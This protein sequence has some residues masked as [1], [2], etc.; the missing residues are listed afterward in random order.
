MPHADAHHL[1]RGGGRTCRQDRGRGGRRTFMGPTR[2]SCAVAAAC[3]GPPWPTRSTS[4]PELIR[5][6]CALAHGCKR[7][8]HD[9][10][11]TATIQVARHLARQPCIPWSDPPL[12]FLWTLRAVARGLRGAQRHGRWASQYGW[13]ELK[14][15]RTMN[16]TGAARQ[17]ADEQRRWTTLG[18]QVAIVVGRA[19]LRS[20]PIPFAPSSRP[21]RGDLGRHA[22]C[23]A[24]N[25]FV[26]VARRRMA[27]S[28]RSTIMARPRRRTAGCKASRLGPIHP[29][30]FYRP[31]VPLL[32]ACA[33]RSAKDAGASQY[34]CFELKEC[35]KMNAT[36]AERQST[37]ERWSLHV[38]IGSL[39]KIAA[40]YLQAD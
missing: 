14:E 2:S 38:R 10:N 11:T 33:T 17:S 27:A 37:D 19:R 8:L 29:W 36:G 34:G 28:A 7:G 5:S 3:K 16:A 39:P 35:W 30:E 6:G 24:G 22:L 32:A 25:L 15:C 20:Q 9:H 23:S 21:A 13:F 31:C 26:P 1:G 12:G 18:T 4:R 40:R